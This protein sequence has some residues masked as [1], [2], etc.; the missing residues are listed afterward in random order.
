ME[1]NLRQNHHYCKVYHQQWPMNL[2]VCPNFHVVINHV[3]LYCQDVLRLIRHVSLV[4]YLP[5]SEKMVV[6]LNF[7]ILFSIS[8]ILSFSINISLGSQDGCIRKTLRNSRNGSLISMNICVNL[9]IKCCWPFIG[10]VGQWKWF[11]YLQSYF[12]H[13]RKSP[14]N[15]YLF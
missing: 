10:H 14:K 4:R 13:I 2:F 7:S 1:K 5:A 3:L 6:I 15:I 12:K 9:E 11:N 8:V